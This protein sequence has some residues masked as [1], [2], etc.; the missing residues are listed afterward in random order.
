MPGKKRRF[1]MDKGSTNGVRDQRQKCVFNDNEKAWKWDGLFL[2]QFGLN[3]LKKHW[4][5]KKN[6]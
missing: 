5:G 1:G 3:L 2:G 6:K 4:L